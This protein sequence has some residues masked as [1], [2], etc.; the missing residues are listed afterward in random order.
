MKTGSKQIPFHEHK[1]LSMVVK[2]I[3]NTGFSTITI[4]I[5]DLCFYDF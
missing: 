2:N 3:T 4:E 1:T 5:G